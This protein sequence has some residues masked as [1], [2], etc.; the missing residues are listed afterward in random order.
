MPPPTQGQRALAALQ[1]QQRQDNVRPSVGSLAPVADNRGSSRLRQP[2]LASM[3]VTDD[4]VDDEDY[5]FDKVPVPRT[6]VTASRVSPA[7]VTELD[8]VG[9]PTHSTRSRSSRQEVAVSPMLNISSSSSPRPP[10]SS[11]PKQMPLSANDVVRAA[12]ALSKAE[13]SA[14]S[15]STS[16]HQPNRRVFV[17]TGNDYMNSHSSPPA[18]RHQQQSGLTAIRSVND[19]RRETPTSTV[20][21]RSDTISTSSPKLKALEHSFVSSPRQGPAQQS[22]TQR[23]LQ[24]E[25]VDLRFVSSFQHARQQQPGSLGHFHQQP[26]TTTQS[27]SNSPRTFRQPVPRSPPPPSRTVVPIVQLPAAPPLYTDFSGFRNAGNTCYAASVLSALLRQPL[28]C[29]E[30]AAFVNEFGDLTIT[31]KYTMEEEYEEPVPMEDE[32]LLPAHQQQEGIDAEDDRT[33]RAGLFEDQLSPVS[34]EETKA[35]Q[36]YFSTPPASQQQNEDEDIRP[37]AQQQRM[38]TKTRTVVKKEKGPVCVLHLALH[39]AVRKLE[40]PQGI[41]AGIGVK[42]IAEA[43]AYYDAYDYFFDREQHDAHEFYVGLVSCL[44]DEAVAAMKQAE[45][46]QRKKKLKM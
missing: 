26:S 28:F 31:R 43:M 5:G 37:P 24:G 42:K 9:S 38:V 17:P 12:T 16:T 8:A 10:L 13:S 34:N 20:P 40:R 6:V 27:W 29:S 46:T 3:D 25:G 14:Y 39:D 7:G 21:L 11:H 18:A 36:E 2:S 44:E 32:P 1:Q 35:F 19:Y 22:T 33:L 4:L 23:R 41:P 30:L 45:A 15:L